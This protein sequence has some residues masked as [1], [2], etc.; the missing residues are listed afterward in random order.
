MNKR[1]KTLI[2]V[3][4]IIG[5]IVGFVYYSFTQIDFIG[6]KDPEVVKANLERWDKMLLE[7]EYRNGTDYCNIKILDSINIEINTG[8]AVGGTIITKDYKLSGDTIIIIDGIKHLENYINSTEMI[9]NHNQ[10]VYLKNINGE[11][12][13][14]QTMKVKFNKLKK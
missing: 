5:G 10:V 13:T 4:T 7:A 2:I 3:I 12:D 8:N 11:F 9:I 14:I 6:H 1:L